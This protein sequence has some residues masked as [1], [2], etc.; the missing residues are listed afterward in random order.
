MSRQGSGEPLLLVHGVLC[1][2]R[3]WVDVVPHLAP[4]YD[5]IAVT[6]LGHRGGR[7]PPRRPVTITDVVDDVEATIDAL[8]FEK[9]HIAGN[10]MGG[11]VALELARRG[12]AISVC[13][14]SPAGLWAS[15]EQAHPSR[16][17]LA[18]VRTTTRLGRPFV[19]L[20]AATGA[21]R[22]L[23]LQASVVHG[24][25][26][27]PRAFTNLTMDVLGC[28]VL[29]D[30][31]ESDERLLPLDST[32]CPITVAWSGEDRVLP[33]SRFLPRAGE[34]LPQA[35]VLVLEGVGHVPMLDDPALVARTILRAAEAANG[36]NPGVRGPRA[37]G[38]GVS[39]V[40]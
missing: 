38:A 7:T 14:L 22:R 33:P 39:R 18:R 5:T 27:T 8:G 3:V 6:A 1:S 36:G 23:A 37:P 32:D 12:R 24:E 10:S 30:L 31:L 15:G 29:D 17:R 25:R 4:R 28:S 11:W 34:L 19:P 13:A 16:R 2:E 21:G 35:R 20:V 40:V 26:V 9:A